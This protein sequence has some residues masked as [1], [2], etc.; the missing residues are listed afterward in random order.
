M[1]NNIAH[2]YEFHTR[3]SQTAYRNL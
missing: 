1:L 3:R 2:E